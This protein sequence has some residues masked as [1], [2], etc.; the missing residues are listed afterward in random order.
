MRTLTVTLID[1]ATE[2]FTVGVHRNAL[3][4]RW[5]YAVTEVALVI[6]Q[7][8]QQTSYPLTNIRKWVLT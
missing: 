3:G 4:L 6:D 7:G 2:D 1:G 8:D 5:D